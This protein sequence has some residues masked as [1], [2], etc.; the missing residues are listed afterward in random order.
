VD[1]TMSLAMAL[2]GAGAVVAGAV[3]F[4]LPVRERLAGTVLALV[5]GAGAGVVALAIGW[6][7]LDPMDGAAWERAFLIASAVGFAAVVAC[8]A[9]VWRR[10]D[11]G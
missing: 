9:I 7:G 2:I 5:A 8:L 6:N 11:R 4:V 3:G 10:R 1:A